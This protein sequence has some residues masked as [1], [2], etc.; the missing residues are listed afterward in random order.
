MRVLPI[1]YVKNG[2]KLAQTLKDEEGRILLRAGMEITPKMKKRLNDYGIYSIYVDDGYSDVELQDVIQPELRQKAVRSI[3]RAFNQCQIPKSKTDS[4]KQHLAR[5]KQREEG[6]RELSKLSESIMNDLLANKDVAVNL[7]DIKTK[8]DFLFQHS[9]NVAVL[10]MI[11]GAELNINARDLK[12]LCLGAM[13]HDIGKTLLPKDLIMKEGNLS[14]AEKRLYEEHP[15]R[16]Y[17]YL[18]G[19]QSISVRARIVTLQHHERIDGCGFPKQIV[20]AHT[21]SKIVSVADT[22]DNLTSDTPRHRAIPAS[23]A[24][25]YILGNSG[26]QYDID[27]VRAFNARVVPYPIGTLVKL[28]DGSVAVVREINQN[29]PMRPIV[30]ILKYHSCI[31]LLNVM[32]LTIKGV[33]YDENLGEGRASDGKRL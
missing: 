25:E 2:H 10:S 31:D 20:D 14:S 16:G 24:L 26:S 12:V 6:L 7:V 11:I 1:Q 32:D 33:C 17:D 5:V 9:M 15:Q 22:Y 18:R 29:F 8:D 4:K 3:K 21:F 13:L 19:S 23:E 28:S 30:E 27:C